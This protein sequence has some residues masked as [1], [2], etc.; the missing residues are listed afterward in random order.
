MAE[1]C[2]QD[3]PP[4]NP[5]SQILLTV[6]GDNFYPPFNAQFQPQ[7]TSKL[8]EEP[9]L[10]M[11]LPGGGK[12]KPVGDPTHVHL[13][14]YVTPLIGAIG[15]IFTFFAPLFIVLDVIRAII[16]II[17]ALFNPVPLILSVIDLFLNVLPP[18]V[19]LFPPFS[20][21]LLAI[22][23]AKLIVALLGALV[24]AIIPIIDQIVGTTVTVALEL[25]RGNIG[26]VDLA[27]IKV[28]ELLQ[29]LANSIGGLLPV[30]FIIELIN[31][32]MSIGSKFF[33]SPEAPCCTTENCPPVIINPPGG[34]AIVTRSVKKFTVKNLIQEIFNLI[35]F[36]LEALSDLINNTISP[37]L[38]TINTTLNQIIDTIATFLDTLN[39]F[40]GGILQSVIDGLNFDELNINVTEINLKLIAPDLFDDII[41]VQPETEFTLKTFIS[42]PNVNGLSSS[43][44]VGYKYKTADMSLIPKYVVEPD[45]IP[46]PGNDPD[47]A[48]MRITVTQNGTTVTQRVR[49]TD[50]IKYVIRDDS[51]NLGTSVD[52][53]L[54]PDEINLVKLELIGLGCYSDIQKVRSGLSAFINADA[55]AAFTAGGASGFSPLLTK[56]NE[57]E[58]PPLP[59]DALN[60]LLN[61]ITEDPKTPVD[62]TPIL[63]QYLNDLG[64]FTDKIVCVG[65]SS[66]KSTFTVS[67]QFPQQSESATLTLTIKDQGGNN[68][69]IGG[70]LPTSSFTA[71]FY[72]TFGELSPVVFDPLT[73]SFSATISA[74]T[75]GKAQLQAAF[76]VRGKE[77]MRVRNFDGFTIT[78]NTQDVEFVP[79]RG[80]FPKS[81]RKDQFIQSRGGR[82]RR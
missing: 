43:V 23:V 19:A 80:T 42:T 24:S 65:A 17:C 63:N 69:L 55:G 10:Q 37:F 71:E 50:G 58:F 75:P 72:T 4:I 51:F 41:L 44:G 15:T 79:D 66:V 22:D 57:T 40:L 73:G 68:I 28:C 25:A 30:S 9:L 2:F 11:V 34:Q 54:V 47:P 36:P 7:D 26:V 8:T 81:R 61:Q 31:L 78:P 3:A 32:F 76:L 59:T 35:N 53:V 45:K 5:L 64:E 1:S 33:C 20:S 48:T 70:V 21:V 16:D 6:L 67:K 39:T 14:E 12:I 18:L 56:I 49:S 74:K 60:Q 46:A 52:Y 77:C 29:Q 38:S 27:S 82:A 62:P 13:S